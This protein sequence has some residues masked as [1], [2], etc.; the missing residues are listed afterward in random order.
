MRKNNLQPYLIRLSIPYD[1]DQN[2][3]VLKISDNTDFRSEWICL[4]SIGDQW[5]VLGDD[6]GGITAESHRT[7]GTTGVH[8]RMKGFTA[9]VKNTGWKEEV[10]HT[11]SSQG[12]MCLQGPYLVLFKD[13][14]GVLAWSC[15]PHITDGIKFYK[16]CTAQAVTGRGKSACKALGTR[17]YNYSGSS[18]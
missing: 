2:C 6:W 4:C 17:G 12:M 3:G 16:S 14:L 7:F 1:I 8:D 11:N 18:R 5:M 10:Q 15:L 13:H 9:Y